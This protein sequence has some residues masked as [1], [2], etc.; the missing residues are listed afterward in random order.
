MDYIECN[1]LITP[2]N[3][4]NEILAATLAD[5]GFESFT[6]TE[7][8]L[9]AYIPDTKFSKDI[10]EN[11]DIMRNKEFTIQFDYK[12]IQDK[13]W[14][15]ECERSYNAVVIA[16]KCCIRAPFHPK[17]ESCKIDIIIEPKMSFGTAHHE[18]T[19]LMIEQILALE[20][21]GK[22]VLD[23]GCG[24]GVLAILAAKLGSTQ[25]TAIDIDEWAYN[26]SVENVQRN[27]TDFINVILGDI[28]LVNKMYDCIFANINRNIL[29]KHI[30]EY[31][32]HLNKSGIL[33]MSGFYN[34]DKPV[35]INIAE[36]NGLKL[37]S[38]SEKN[39]WV[40]LKFKKTH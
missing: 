34:A 6:E 21:K 19:S 39:N 31:V 23:M 29:I 13:N 1:F 3:P 22:K 26:N 2:L 24:T 36:S 33:L 18:T 5:V 20:L 4:G 9:I 11:L 35:I 32:T 27:E 10:I 15:E 7:K 17:N 28:E 38:E 12:N 37:V 8:G 30:P 25:I 14:N 40:V 16:K